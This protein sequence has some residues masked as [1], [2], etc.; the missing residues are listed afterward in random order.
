[1]SLARVLV[2]GLKILAVCVVFSLSLV[3]GGA[4]SGWSNIGQQAPQS[5][6][7]QQVPEQQT[8][9]AAT[10][11]AVARICTSMKGMLFSAIPVVFLY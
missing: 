2:P 1:M 3:I 10:G 4:L 11:A 9:E 6:T 8:T 7:V 5:P